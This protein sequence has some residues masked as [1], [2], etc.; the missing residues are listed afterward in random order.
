MTEIAIIAH[1]SDNAL[2]AVLPDGITTAQFAVLQHLTVR[3]PEQT[4]SQIA[5][6]MQVAPPTMSSTVRKLE[7]KGLVELV[8]DAGD[9][10]IKWVRLTDAGRAMREAGIA[11]T[12]P[13]FESWGSGFAPEHWD[14][15]LAL[16]RPVRETLDAMRD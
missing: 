8:P 5:G 3:G 14:R 7:D 6:A 4:I 13:L 1:L 12:Q 15:L 16:L 11:A 10:R 9:R 2:A